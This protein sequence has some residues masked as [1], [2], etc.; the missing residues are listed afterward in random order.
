MIEQ[1]VVNINGIEHFKQLEFLMKEISHERRQII[2]RYVFEKNKIQSL[3]AERLL[4]Y[5]L[6]TQYGMNQEEIEFE[7]SEYGKPFLKGP[8]NYICFNL[9]HS[10]D[11]VVCSIG[12]SNMGIDVERINKRDLSFV[13]RV[14][15]GEEKEVWEIKDIDEK[16]RMICR[17]WTLKESYSKY[18]GKGLTIPF[19]TLSFK[20]E[21]KEVIFCI[22]SRVDNSCYF[23]VNELA[24]DYYMTLCTD[25]YEKK[26]VTTIPKYI[27]WEELLVMQ[28]KCKVF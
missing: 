28:E 20:Q 8:Y 4:R 2:E 6:Y 26:N 21:E 10:G 22:D 18:I 25:K 16:N 24:D 12:T 19:E 7:Y 13:R 23:C 9:S 14:L 5:I 11:F 15:S 3:I 27:R 17:I 1:F